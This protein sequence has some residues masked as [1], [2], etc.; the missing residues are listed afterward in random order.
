MKKLKKPLIILFVLANLYAI[1]CGGL[2]F[3]QDNLLFHPRQL[4]QD[5]NFQFEHPAEEVW[6][7]VDND[8]RL[9]GLHFKV[10]NEKGVLLYY[11]GNAGSLARWGEIVQ[12]LIDLNYS[13]IIMDYRQ[14]GKSSGK[15]TEEALYEDSLLWYA[16]AKA[17][18]PTTPI[19]IYGRSLGTTFATYVASQEKVE[20][21]ILETPFYSIRDEAYARF[22]ILPIDKLL[23]YKFPTHAFINSVEAPIEIFHGTDDNVVNYDHGKRLFE[24]INSQKKEFTTIPNGGHNDLITFAAYRDRI[25]TILE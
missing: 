5:Y 14:Y 7:D 9:H 3:F 12:Y 8:T 18:Y 21:L 23:K 10:P 6:I 2:Y 15:L 4:A 16:F 20:R 19:S 17:Q 1:L 13:V 25:N 24:T 11:H 22:P